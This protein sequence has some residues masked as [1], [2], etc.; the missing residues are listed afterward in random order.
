VERP[1][2]GECCVSSERLAEV[3]GWPGERVRLGTGRL[4]GTRRGERFAI[5]AAEAGA[6][7]EARALAETGAGT[8]G[9][10][11]AADNATA[12]ERPTAGEC[13]VSSERLAEVEVTEVGQSTSW[14]TPGPRS[15][16]ARAPRAGDAAILI[17]PGPYALQRTVG[18][19]GRDG[20]SG[21]EG[22]SRYAWLRALLADHG[23]GFLAAAEPGAAADFEI[24]EADGLLE[25]RDAG[26]NPIPNL[27]PPLPLLASGTARELVR[28]LGHLARYWNVRAL[29]NSDDTSPLA[30]TL[31]VWVE[32]RG[33]VAAG[34]PPEIPA[35]ADLRLILENTGEQVLN[36]AVLDL[37][38]DWSVQQV[39]PHR[40]VAPWATL[41]PDAPL[42]VDLTAH[43][44]QG[45]DEGVD[46]LLAIAATSPF[47]LAGLERPALHPAGAVTRSGHQN[48]AGPLPTD[49]FGRL[50]AALGA[51]RPPERVVRGADTA[52]ESWTTAAVEVRVVR[53]T[54]TTVV[55]RPSDWSARNRA[56][57]CRTQSN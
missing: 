35:G 57:A 30:G 18:W 33:P 32:R 40:E 10:V 9:A 1:T 47:D 38:P 36:V 21:G 43:L 6:V 13:C 39:H 48:G 8:G 12:V 44:P 5:M 54:A 34:G 37:A 26:G 46:L 17:D 41:E 24:A 29:E 16:G 15:P 23:D 52:P 28:R 3:E 31:R 53:E 4:H 27:G 11:A 49:P 56:A 55:D 51:E 45:L 22:E 25:I 2:A 19:I 14:A 20:G 42:E 7:G 50:L